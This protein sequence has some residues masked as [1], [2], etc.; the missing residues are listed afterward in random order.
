MIQYEDVE[1][2]AKFQAELKSAAD[3]IAA[4]KTIQECTARIIELEKQA[5]DQRDALYD[6]VSVYGQDRIGKQIEEVKDQI[7]DDWDGNKKTIEYEFGLLRFVTTKSLK[8]GDGGRLLEHI[9]ENTS[10]ATAVDKYL[11]GFL[12]IPTKAYV[13]VHE[14]GEGI[15]KIEPRT[16]VKLK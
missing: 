4:D 16:T 11:K 2:L 12:L 10:T 7:V 6:L 15:A 9:I 1:K 3:E 13:D 14:L 8:I 5:S